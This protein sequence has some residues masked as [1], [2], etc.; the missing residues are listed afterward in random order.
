MAL[1][2]SG[3][4]SIPPPPRSSRARKTTAGSTARKPA[5]EQ[6]SDKRKERIDAITGIAQ[7]GS[8]SCI[9]MKQYPD[10]GAIN[11]YAPAL[12]TELAKLAEVKEPIAKAVDSLSEVG[13]YAG[14]I[15]VMMPFCLQLAANH[16]MLK[17]EHLKSYGVK[18]PSQLEAEVKM[19]MAKQAMEAMQA[20]RAAEEE[21][22]TMQ[23][24]IDR[25]QAED[26]QEKA[27]R[28]GVVIQ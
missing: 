8:L 10:A 25:W 24:D 26:D 15:T 18:D 19:N 14:L 1:D 21:M 20:Q 23:E 3:A 7:L 6:V 9:I 12:A 4:S 2:L 28:M 5:D 27:A 13:P 22:R 16:K 17:A 11:M